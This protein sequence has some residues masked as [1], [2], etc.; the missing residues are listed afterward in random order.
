MAPVDYG[1]ALNYA[2]ND[3][4]E[5][6]R[7]R[8]LF[9]ILLV[10]T[11]AFRRNRFSLLLNRVM[12]TLGKESQGI[13]QRFSHGIQHPISLCVGDKIPLPC[14]CRRGET[15]SSGD[16]PSNISATRFADR[17]RAREQR[18]CSH[19]GFSPNASV[20]ESDNAENQ[21]TFI[22]DVTTRVSTLKETVLGPTYLG[23]RL[24]LCHCGSRH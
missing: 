21:G 12:M 13:S 7:K 5:D 14:S 24:L 8:F 18:P 20:C 15:S 16:Y 10:K 6:N 19:L 17:T 1:S 9:S 2:W 11:F 3:N 23:S 4:R 22:P